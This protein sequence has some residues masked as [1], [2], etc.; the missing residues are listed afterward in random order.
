MA[1]DQV[2]TERYSWP[3][4]TREWKGTIMSSDVSHGRDALRRIAAVW[5]VDGDRVRWVEQ[6]FDWWP[7]DFKVAVRAFPATED[8]EDEQGLAWR[9]SVRT[10][11]LKGVR[12]ADAACRK[13][14]AAVAFMAPT[15]S[16]IYPPPDMSEKHPTSA[17][18]LVWFQSTVYL[19]EDNLGWLPE[20]FARMAILQPIDAQKHATRIAAA[21]GG[22]PDVSEPQGEGATGYRD[23]MLSVADAL[24]FPAGKQP[25][26]WLGTSE[27]EEF[28]ERLG[29]NDQCFGN[30]DT[31][32]LTAETPFGDDSA[33]IQ[34]GTDAPHPFIGTG[35]LNSLVLPL[36]RS[37]EEVRDEAAWLNFF[38]GIQW[39]GFPQLGSWV[40]KL[41]GS[42]YCPAHASF[43][44]NALFM[45]HLGTNA[46]LWQMGR[47]RWVKRTFYPKLQDRTMMEILKARW[48]LMGLEV[49][50]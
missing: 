14:I 36:S 31:K 1:V 44:P 38:E 49:L 27:F 50:E 17:S 22:T 23:D 33:L 5:Q 40:P 41:R 2:M 19:R 48:K 29:R 28:A 30:G 12:I 34:L 8:Q 4:G 16:V 35:L 20:F 26:R 3:R 7:G 13:D 25:S 11:F 21:L 18:D 6:G 47:A 43:I 24:Y 45:P 37:E 39:T 32:G 9:V 15:Y 42:G 46:A 10:D